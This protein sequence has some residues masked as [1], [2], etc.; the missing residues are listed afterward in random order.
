MFKLI[1]ILS[2][3]IYFYF[4]YCIIKN[5]LNFSKHIIKIIKRMESEKN[6]NKIY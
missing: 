6:E 2:F 5:S 4:L 1:S 3:L